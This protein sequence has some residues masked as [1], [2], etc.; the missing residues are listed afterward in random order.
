MLNA[1]KLINHIK[2]TIPLPNLSQQTLD[3]NTEEALVR[4]KP[5]NGED[6]GDLVIAKHDGIFYRAKVVSKNDGFCVVST[7]FVNRNIFFFAYL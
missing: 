4:M 5:Y 2:R 6:I 1:F 7:V 3:M